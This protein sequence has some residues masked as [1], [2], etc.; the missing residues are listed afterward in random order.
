MEFIMQ[1]G[2]EVD[3]TVEMRFIVPILELTIIGCWKTG[4][5]EYGYLA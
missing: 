2:F 1:R 5:L 4:R 3:K